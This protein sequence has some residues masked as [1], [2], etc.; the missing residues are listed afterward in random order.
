MHNDYTCNSNGRRELDECSL[1]VVAKL[2]LFSEWLGSVALDKSS[3]IGCKLS[4]SLSLYIIAVALNT[5]V[6]FLFVK[7]VLSQ[8][9]ES[10]WTRV[11][12]GGNVVGLLSAVGLS[13]L[14]N[15]QVR[16][17]SKAYNFAWHRCT[18]FRSI[19]T[20]YKHLFC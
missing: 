6:R 1:S 7:T 16:F 20:N 10:K 11:N 8:D 9:T 2:L 3:N 13:M 5:I 4:F 19:T 12:I 15:F 17:E 14:A 18:R